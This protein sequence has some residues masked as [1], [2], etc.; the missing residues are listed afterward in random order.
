MLDDVVEILRLDFGIPALFRVQ[1]DVRSLLAGAEAHVRFDFHVV[2][3]LRSDFFFELGC[4]LFRTARFTIDVLANQASSSHYVSPC[5]PNYSARNRDATRRSARRLIQLHL[6][7]PV[8]ALDNLGEDFF[9]FLGGQGFPQMFF[10]CL[11]MQQLSGDTECFADVLA[12]RTIKFEIRS[13]KLRLSLGYEL[14]ELIDEF[15]ALSH[16]VTARQVIELIFFHRT[17]GL[18]LIEASLQSPSVCPMSRR[19]VICA[20]QVII[21]RKPL[22]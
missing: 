7:N 2:K 22:I 14:I 13:I 8:F 3:T 15:C 6:R 17:L 16:I 21:C 1:D 9:V 18:M 10:I 11:R 19:R 4:E 12:D 5:A 20:E